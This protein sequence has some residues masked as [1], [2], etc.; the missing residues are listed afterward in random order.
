MKKDIRGVTH[1][2]GVGRNG[3]VGGL[4]TYRMYKIGR[5][6]TQSVILLRRKARNA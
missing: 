6:A 1:E 3:K 2:T 5:Y 4:A